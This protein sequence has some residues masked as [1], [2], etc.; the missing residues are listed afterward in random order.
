MVGTYIK[1]FIIGFALCIVALA[2]AGVAYTKVNGAQLLSVQSGSMVPAIN[3]GDLV[4]VTRVPASQLAVGDII[5]FKN[6]QNQ[7]QTVTHRVVQLPSARTNGK[8]LTKGDANSI[9]DAPV[10]P[11]SVLGKSDYRVPF[12]GY[13]VDFVRQ[14]IGL[15]LVIYI[16]AM[17]VVW[18]EMKRLA[19]YYRTQQIY[20]LA[21][22]KIHLRLPK[23]SGSG[24]GKKP[25]IAGAQ[26][27]GL[28]LAI[29]LAIAVPV[30][31]AIRNTATMTGNSIATAE[32]VNHILMRRVEF[33]CASDNT[34]QVNKLPEIF[35]Y[36]PTD[37]DIRTGGWYLESGNGRILTLPN[38]TVFDAKDIYD[39]EPDLQAGVKYDGD[40]LALFDNTGKLVDAI[41]WGTDTTY[42][43]PSLPGIQDGSVFRRFSLVFDTDRAVDWAVSIEGCD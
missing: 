35:F 14:P 23:P 25:F 30:H 40:F 41:S 7:K 4:T 9:I 31:A 8:I 21:G 34:N 24:G 27:V 11:R 15:L 12:A 36:N 5:T 33:Q 2:V 10:S 38:K 19:Q 37:A 32:Q 39:I 1:R 43:N 29:S 3:K 20:R 18:E 13:A 26:T 16:P 28:C 42:L 17:M 6:P 22:A